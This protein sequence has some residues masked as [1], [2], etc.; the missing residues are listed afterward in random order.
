MWIEI[1]MLRVSHSRG[2]MN[3]H[4]CASG[5]EVGPSRRSNL[6]TGDVIAPRKVLKVRVA[7]ARVCSTTNKQRM[8][9]AAEG[10][11]GISL[12]PSDRPVGREAGWGRGRLAPQASPVC[13]LDQ[14]MSTFLWSVQWP[15]NRT[16]W[17]GVF[18][19]SF[20]LRVS[21]HII[22]AS[23]ASGARQRRN[24]TQRRPIILLC[25]T[26]WTVRI[27][28][29]CAHG[30]RVLGCKGGGGRQCGEDGM[31]ATGG[32]GERAQVI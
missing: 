21:R 3:L 23:S 1:S 9:G 30:Q 27:G 22:G 32:A 19:V 15:V 16:A 8:E 24:S 28:L 18:C 25:R 14:C 13:S 31:R 2:A 10:F 11:Q 4:H 12:G 29:G 5:Q 6:Q 17:L 20:L 7:R 26:G